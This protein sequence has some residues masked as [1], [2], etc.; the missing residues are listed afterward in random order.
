MLILLISSLD[1]NQSLEIY[2]LPLTSQA[3]NQERQIIC[4]H[5]KSNQCANWFKEAQK[6][7]TGVGNQTIETLEFI[8]PRIEN[9]TIAP[10]RNELEDV[11][12]SQNDTLLLASSIESLYYG[13]YPQFRHGFRDYRTYNPHYSSI[14]NPAYNPLGSFYSLDDSPSPSAGDNPSQNE[15]SYPFHRPIAQQLGFTGQRDAPL[16]SVLLQA[17]GFGPA[18]NMKPA[19]EYPS[20]PANNVK[21]MQNY[22]SGPANNL[23]QTQEYP[24][25][26]QAREEIL[27]KYTRDRL[28][29]PQVMR[30]FDLS[31]LHGIKQEWDNLH[32]YRVQQQQPVAA[33]E[34]KQS[35]EQPKEREPEPPPRA[36]K[37]IE[38]PP[39]ENKK[40]AEQVVVNAPQ[41]PVKQPQGV[42]QNA[43]QPSSSNEQKSPVAF[44]RIPA[45]QIKL[46]TS[47]R[48]G[49]PRF[50]AS[51]MHNPKVYARPAPHQ[52]PVQ[53][54]LS[55][56]IQ[57]GEALVSE[58][59]KSAGLK[60][61]VASGSVSVDEIVNFLQRLR[62]L[63]ISERDKPESEQLPAEIEQDDD[64]IDDDGQIDKE[65][66]EEL[67]RQNR[68]TRVLP[69]SHLF[70]GSVG[71]VN[72]SRI[73]DPSEA[74]PEVDE[75]SDSDEARRP[76]PS[77]DSVFLKNLAELSSKLSQPNDDPKKIRRVREFNLD[78]DQLNQL[79]AGGTGSGHPNGGWVPNLA[80]S[81]NHQVEDLSED[82]EEAEAS[83][84]RQPQQQEQI[85]IEQLVDKLMSSS[86]LAT[87][88]LQHES[89]PNDP[90]QVQE[91]DVV[92]DEDDDEEEDE[93]DENNADQ[94]AEAS[95]PVQVSIV[96]G[97]P[98]MSASGSELNGAKLFPQRR[99]I[100]F[101]SVLNRND[102]WIPI[103]T[104]T[105]TVD[106]AKEVARRTG[107]SD[108]GS[109]E[110]AEAEKKRRRRKRKRRKKRKKR[111][112]ND[113]EKKNTKNGD[114]VLVIGNNVLSRTDLIRLIGVL[115]KMASKREPSRERDASRRLLRFLVK[116]ALEEYKKNKLADKKSGSTNSRDPIRDVLRSVLNGPVDVKPLPL[117]DNDTSIELSPEPPAQGFG[118]DSNS[119]WDNGNL[120]DEEDVK[121]GEQKPLANPELGK[122]LNEMS[123]DLE[124]YFD[125]DF[126]E[127]LADKG[128][129]NNSD[130]AVKVLH[131]REPKLRR[132]S[133]SGYVLPVPI[134]GTK[135]VEAADEEDVELDHVR[136]PA[137]VRARR[138][139]PGRRFRPIRVRRL[140][141][142]QRRKAKDGKPEDEE[143]D[144]EEEEAEDAE[145]EKGRGTAES[146]QEEPISV[147]ARE[148]RRRSDQIR[149]PRGEASVK[150][151]ADET[152]EDNAAVDPDEEPDPDPV[153]KA[154]ESGTAVDE[155]PAGEED[156]SEDNNGEQGGRTK[157]VPRKRRRRRRKRRGD[158][159]KKPIPAVEVD[160]DRRDE[161]PP[162]ITGGK[163]RRP[164]PVELR[165]H[166]PE[167]QDRKDNS[168]SSTVK[169]TAEPEKPKSN[170]KASKK[171]SEE[172]EKE[173]NKRKEVKVNN[174][175]GKNKKKKKKK[176]PSSVSDQKK[177]I[178]N[179][180]EA[181][182]E[183]ED[184]TK[185]KDAR[186]R[187]DRSE[188]REE[189]KSAQKD[190]VKKKK[191]KRKKKKK[192]RDG[193]SG[194]Q[195][196][197]K[198][199]NGDKQRNPEEDEDYYN[200]GT[201]Y[202]K[203]CDDDGK[204][205]VSVQSSSPTLSKAIKARDKP[206]IVKHLGKWVEKSD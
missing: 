176:K 117:S 124:Q 1:V 143:D 58:K 52:R 105:M 179:N 102:S 24:I 94:N 31:R 128:V 81:N 173:T 129:K 9:N 125:K 98:L 38:S 187:R 15:Q 6:Q 205:K 56:L 42:I 44:Y 123:E 12:L 2:A 109:E 139:P 154:D 111:K 7:S 181:I 26:D 60:P 18:N 155:E 195:V 33:K 118:R 47:T 148:G 93:E 168:T 141:P 169:P 69:T 122:S 53:V 11:L 65:D 91:E 184:L 70:G 87:F 172:S 25:S 21:A 16:Q 54:N 37:Q 67:K 85:P 115:N 49:Q 23:K 29:D 43:Y 101:S 202:S 79:H 201:S 189:S 160:L 166:L 185:V 147:R 180:I 171:G 90:S 22:P 51:K 134:Y 197:G 121:Y 153:V 175:S 188:Q 30:Q 39:A 27:K 161:I 174:S 100:S 156:N 133:R 74:D 183:T 158:F 61:S 88:G 41:V 107:E 131:R 20:G 35:G 13:G 95:Q 114:L 130:A 45:Q 4:D 136:V 80:H 92:G 96:P 72:E 36:Q 46:P 55:S 77:D 192:K 142:Q 112:R 144:E 59:V 73:S 126:F 157:Q 178:E 50:P 78:Q 40:P 10:A 34:Q 8:N 165:K 116:L 186:K 104:V 3:S 113:A 194:E 190:E 135:Q 48:I 97:T 149:D 76:S 177:D 83:V 82:D 198:P 28:V 159:I 108:R 132:A 68:L 152:V 151:D 203:V 146:E 5:Q 120:N 140:R 193:P 206:A 150:S 66:L 14:P 17:Y 167:K 57:P 62:P 204:C 106:K 110:D 145:P 199:T 162:P 191:K 71:L 99:E 182:E 75:F 89:V 137:L 32:R 103:D 163:Y 127:D 196:T 138:L 170:K 64:L 164:P 86:R 119:R 63:A 84:R 19:Q 200:E